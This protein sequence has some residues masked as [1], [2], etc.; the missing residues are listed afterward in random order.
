M[1]PRQQPCNQYIR[2][3]DD[4]EAACDHAT[5][6]KHDDDPASREEKETNVTYIFVANDRDTA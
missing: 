4:H 5:I 1:I 6:S 3:E 2:A